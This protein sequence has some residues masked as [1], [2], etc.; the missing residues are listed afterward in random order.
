MEQLVPFAP[1]GAA[2][3]TALV[4]TPLAILLAR[5]A[6]AVDRPKSDR[7]HSAPTPL[8][9]G[10]AIVCGLLAGLATSGVPTAQVLGVA[11]GVVILF[12]TGLVDD[13]SGLRPV[14]KLV[15]QIAATG[16]LL[17]LGVRAGWPEIPVLSILLTFLWVVGITNAVNLLDNMD[18][19]AAGIAAISGVSVA[20]CAAL[21][22]GG[23]A[24]AAVLVALS[25]AGGA[26]GFLPWNRHPARIFMGDAGSLPL[27]FALAASGLLATHR[28]AG[29]LAFVLAAPLLALAVPILDTAL[30]SVVRRW[31]GRRISQ[32]GRDHLS[33]RLVALGMPERDAVHVLWLASAVLG[34]FAVAATSLGWLG[35]FVLLAI[36]IC[37]SAVMGV[38]LG[39]VKVYAPA[40]RPADAERSEELRR[41]F[42]NYA[43]ILGPFA[44]DLVLACAAY[45]GAYLLRYDGNVP[46]LDRVLL[47]DSLPVVVAV[48]MI[49]L[50][51]FRA[52][53]GV[54]R[55]FGVTDAADLARGIGAASIAGTLVV[56]FVFRESVFSRAVFVM[57]AALLVVLLFGARALT[58]FLFDAFGCFHQGG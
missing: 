51:A 12:V 32:G 16:V 39:H 52:Y 54:W 44:T 11:A 47:E 19:L 30:V 45:V 25:V 37:V 48:Q 22:P 53:R 26:A 3:I 58:R 49:A 2:L 21:V 5:R 7:W 17:A 1:F 23:G 20:A 29:Q 42:L 14:T 50:T 31:N 55:Y 35:T 6:G 41:T 56:V 28:E 24:G 8:L 4:V 10:I 33:H 38:V 9:G 43:R 34:G 40:A 36:G 13:I 27:G 46:L 15:A 57:D 18:G